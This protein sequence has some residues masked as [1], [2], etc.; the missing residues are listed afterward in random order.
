MVGKTKIDTPGARRRS[1]QAVLDSSGWAGGA[2]VVRNPGYARLLATVQQEPR[3]HVDCLPR[4]VQCCTGRLPLRPP[5]LEP[6]PGILHE[7]RPTAA[8]AS[9]HLPSTPAMAQASNHKRMPD[10]APDLSLSHGAKIPKI[11]PGLA[12]SPLGPHRPSPNSD[13]SGSV[14]KRLATSSRTGQACDRCKVG[15]PP[16]PRPRPRLR[17]TTTTSPRSTGAPSSSGPRTEPSQR[18]FPCRRRRVC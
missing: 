16:R 4:I 2:R 5:A 11:E 7:L 18:V 12:Q 13:F 15:R 14:K 3:V 6:W 17:P 8:H 10:T 9:R 1:V